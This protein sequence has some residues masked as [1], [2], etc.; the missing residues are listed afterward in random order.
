M[1]LK[2]HEDLDAF[3]GFFSG[4]LIQHLSDRDHNWA[5]FSLDLDMIPNHVS[6]FPIHFIILLAMSVGHTDSTTTLN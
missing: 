6:I 1:L 2:N 3:A 4:V 5:Y